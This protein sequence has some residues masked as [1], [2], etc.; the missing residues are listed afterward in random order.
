MAINWLSVDII[1]KYN[2]DFDPLELE[3]SP[4]IEED[5]STLMDHYEDMLP[6]IEKA[7]IMEVMEFVST[8]LSN[9]INQENAKNI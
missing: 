3:V 9:K 7:S 1:K 6:M 8:I 4:S 2:P 5:M